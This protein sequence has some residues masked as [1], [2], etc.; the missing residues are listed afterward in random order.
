M[1]RI[2]PEFLQYLQF[3]PEKIIYAFISGFFGLPDTEE[4]RSG[5]R[6]TEDETHRRLKGI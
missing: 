5:K 3:V 6:G 2:L 1:G 4:K